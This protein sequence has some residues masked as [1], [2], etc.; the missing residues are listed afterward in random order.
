M[1]YDELLNHISE[2]LNDPR[3]IINKTL[4][5]GYKYYN[6][7]LDLSSKNGQTLVIQTDNR[8]FILEISYGYHNSI[9]IESKELAEKWIQKLEDQ[10]QINTPR[11]FNDILS[12]AVSETDVV[13]V[14]F[15]R[16][17][18]MKKLFDSTKE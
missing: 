6:L 13:D 15:W 2:N 18:K 17:F 3:I 1:I 16:D 11:V 5:Y 9:T 12:K 7:N 14:D 8:N 4:K 10:Y